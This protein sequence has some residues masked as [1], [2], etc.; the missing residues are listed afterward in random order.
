MSLKEQRQP[1]L[2]SSSVTGMKQ[3]TPV[4]GLVE[5]MLQDPLQSGILRICMQ[6]TG[7]GLQS[8]QDRLLGILSKLNSFQLTFTFRFM[9][10]DGLGEKKIW[11][12]ED[13]D[14]VEVRSWGNIFS[15]S[16]C[17]QLI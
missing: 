14:L 9:P 16:Y 17:Q 12:V 2:S 4:L 3:T 15:Q 11:R 5:A 10:D 8:L 6:T 7:R 1:C 13:M